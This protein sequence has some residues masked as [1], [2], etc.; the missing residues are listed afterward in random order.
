V[1]WTEVL[2]QGLPIGLGMAVGRGVGY[3]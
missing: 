1:P 3:S 2:D